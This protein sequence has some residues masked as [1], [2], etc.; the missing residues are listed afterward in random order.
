MAKKK[1]GKEKTVTVTVTLTDIPVEIWEEIKKTSIDASNE[2]F[3]DKLEDIEKEITIPFE[4]GGINFS[5]IGQILG[6]ALANRTLQNRVEKKP[7]FLGTF[8]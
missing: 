4:E 7:I 5:A 6:H 3:A 1:H 8:N 2:Y